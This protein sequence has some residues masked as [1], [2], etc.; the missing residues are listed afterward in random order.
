MQRS[1][2]TCMCADIIS[3]MSHQDVNIVLLYKIECR[4][5]YVDINSCASISISYVIL[6]VVNCIIM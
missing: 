1:K 3:E 5:D 6:H 2:A 4:L